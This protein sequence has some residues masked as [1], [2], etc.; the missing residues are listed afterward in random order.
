MEELENIKLAGRE[1]RS[2]IKWK[3]KG[4]QRQRNFFQPLEK[5]P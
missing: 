3:I 1:T 5:K 2:K 4:T